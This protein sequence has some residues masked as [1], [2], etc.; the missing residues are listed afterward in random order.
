M[1]PEEKAREQLAV[2]T[3]NGLGIRRKPT[4]SI[5]GFGQLSDAFDQRDF[6]ADL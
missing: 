5:Y 1:S 2:E 4:P 3:V 6:V